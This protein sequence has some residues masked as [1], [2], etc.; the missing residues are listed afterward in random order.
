MWFASPIPVLTDCQRLALCETPHFDPRQLAAGVGAWKNAPGGGA[1]WLRTGCLGKAE[2]F[3]LHWS[4]PLPPVDYTT[5]VVGKQAAQLAAS[6]GPCS[7]SWPGAFRVRV[8]TTTVCCVVSSI[9]K[10]TRL[11]LSRLL[12]R[13]ESC[14]TPDEC[15]LVPLTLAKGPTKAGGR[16]APCV[17]ALPRGNIGR[18]P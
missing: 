11:I 4:L 2:P 3:R 8:L 12:S 18:G 1:A 13:F 7:C 5:G 10:S 6:F 9:G 16:R 17:S 14:T 15:K